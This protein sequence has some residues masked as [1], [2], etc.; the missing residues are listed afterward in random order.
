MNIDCYRF[1]SNLF[2][3]FKK[4]QN[5]SKKNYVIKAFIQSSL[6]YPDKGL[7]S[8]I[9]SGH[10]LFPGPEILENDILPSDRSIP[11]LIP[12]KTEIFFSKPDSKNGILKFFAHAIKKMFCENFRF[13]MLV[14]QSQISLR[15]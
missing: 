12:K 2:K 6:F 8:P 4:F 5:F 13:F 10:F 15:N 14:S 3:N 11:D 7:I 1:E 9:I